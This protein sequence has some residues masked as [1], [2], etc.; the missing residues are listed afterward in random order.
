VTSWPHHRCCPPSES[1][2]VNLLLCM[3]EPVAVCST[4]KCAFP[5]GYGHPRNTREQTAGITAYIAQAE[6]QHIPGVR[7][8]K[9]AVCDCWTVVVRRGLT[10]QQWTDHDQP[11]HDGHFLYAQ[12]LVHCKFFLIQLCSSMLRFILSRRLKYTC[13]LRFVWYAKCLADGLIKKQLQH[14]TA[15]TIGTTTKRTRSSG[16]R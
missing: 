3:S 12:L 7:L 5:W 16:C 15:S 13:I 4:R 11:T 8:I 6:E 9:S 1:H 14:R 10:C 2:W